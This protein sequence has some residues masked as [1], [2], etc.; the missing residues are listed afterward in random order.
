M[1]I[2]IV[3][4]AALALGGCATAP[5]RERVVTVEVKVPV[6]CDPPRPARPASAVDALPLGAGVGAQMRAL[7]ADRVRGKAHVQQL[8]NALASCR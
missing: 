2:A 5:P 4:I 1:K 7:R 8:E 3:L 6:P